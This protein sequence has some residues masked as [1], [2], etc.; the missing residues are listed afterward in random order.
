MEMLYHR[1]V[2]QS[3]FLTCI[4]L[5]I[6]KKTRLLI[7]LYSLKKDSMDKFAE[8]KNK[9]NGIFFYITNMQSD[10]VFF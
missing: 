4:L 8:N 6:Q 1:Q 10:V 2:A 7:V 3:D 5:F 9:K